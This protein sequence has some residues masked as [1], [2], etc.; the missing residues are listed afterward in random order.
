[1]GQYYYVLAKEGEQRN[2][3][4]NRTLIE[5]GQKNRTMGKLMEHSWFLNPFVNAVCKKYMTLK[6]PQELFGWAITQTNFV[7]NLIANKTD[8]PP[9]LYTNISLAVG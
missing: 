6:N 5:N 7:V 1:M 8:F 3:V 2:E 4:F 9:K